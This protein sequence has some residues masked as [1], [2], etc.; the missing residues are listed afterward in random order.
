ME[1]QKEFETSPNGIKTGA[2]YI[3]TVTGKLFAYKG[4]PN[5]SGVYWNTS[6]YPA[7]EVIDADKRLKSILRKQQALRDTFSVDGKFFEIQPIDGSAPTKF[8]VRVDSITFPK[9]IWF[10]Y[11][12]YT[13]V[14]KA[15]ADTTEFPDQITDP[16][17]SWEIEIEDNNQAY[18]VTH[19]VSAGGKAHYN[20]LG[21]LVRPPW[22]NARIW[23]TGQLGLDMGLFQSG[24]N[25]L[26]TVYG[27]YN[28]QFVERI[29]EWAGKYSVTETWIVSSGSAIE[30]FNVNTRTSAE[31]GKTTVS[32]EGNI[33]GLAQNTMMHDAPAEMYA[34]AQTKFA[35]VQGFLVSRAQAV[36]GVTLNTSPLNTAIGRNPLNGT[37][38]YN[39]EYDNRATNLIPGALNESFVVVD[40]NPADIFAKI[41]VLGRRA[42]PV[43]QDIGSRTERNRQLE[44]N[45]TM[46][47]PTGTT[48]AD[49]LSLRPDLNAIVSGFRPTDEQVFMERNTDTWDLKTGRGAKSVA[50]TYERD[51]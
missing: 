13:I 34:N 28:R 18:R 51:D 2:T 36:A 39:Y 11:T 21:T 46:P 49:F 26:P 45:Y 25:H 33:R 44:I 22:Q 32:I 6:G 4:S 5:S 10:E 12:D 17:D 27:G 41:G 19:N 37:I 35:Q 7:D 16:E 42:G 48:V 23:V 38:T 24:V 30:E 29:D 20:S 50:W 47:V 9:D 14:L 8:N 3:L 1:I 15:D 31:Q 43:L 40:N